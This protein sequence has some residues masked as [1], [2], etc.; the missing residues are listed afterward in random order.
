M[1]YWGTFIGVKTYGIS[2]RV[3]RQHI[4]H[5]NLTLEKLQAI[6]FCGGTYLPTYLLFFQGDQ[7]PITYQGWSVSRW[8]GLFFRSIPHYK[9]VGVSHSGTFSVFSLGSR[10]S[11]V[12]CPTGLACSVVEWAIPFNS[13]KRCSQHHGR[14]VQSCRGGSCMS[15]FSW[16]RGI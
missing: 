12:A 10:P 2:F 13:K 15:A 3:F 14:K 6:V 8:N 1:S 5:R 16:G 11:M 9:L 4:L 7:C